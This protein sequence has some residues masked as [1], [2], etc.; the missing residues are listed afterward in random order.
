M[1]AE[2]LNGEANEPATIGQRLAR[3]R[4][5]AKL[6]LADV[7]GRTRVPIRHLQS[8]EAADWESLPA[9]TYAVGFVRAYAEAVGLD[10][11]ELGRELRQHLGAQVRR[12]PA[13]EYYEPADPARVPPRALAIAAAIIAV[14]LV[15]GYLLW[16]GSA[17]VE[18]PA[19]PA[20]GTEVPLAQAPQRAPPPATPA[21]APTGPV[22]LTAIGEVWLKVSEGP[23]G[24]ALFQGTLQPG[25]T[26]AIPATAQRPMLRT[27]RPQMVRVR[28]GATD[29]GPIDEVEH[30]VS[31]ISLLPQ[32]LA[33]RASARTA[34][35]APA[36]PPGL[37]PPPA[38]T[39][40]APAPAPGAAPLRPPPGQ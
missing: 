28:A 26:F 30:V 3:A 33:A 24:A 8:I 34:A 17:E 18:A 5:A 25:Q 37:P 35:G 4:E 19:T 1:A 13:P 15:V 20:N 27:G 7:A 10:G 39:S 21:T 22:T 11:A 6:S 23:D 32:D 29:F 2:E 9:A 12:A 14:V 16:R 40:L 31:E 38:A 36:T